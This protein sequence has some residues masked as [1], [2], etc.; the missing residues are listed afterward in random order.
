MPL[1]SG[2]NESCVDHGR[3]DAID[4]MGGRRVP[5]RA[6]I[7]PRHL[8]VVL[9]LEGYD[10]A[11]VGYVVPSLVD[12]W[13]VDPSVFTEALAVGNVGLLLKST[14]AGL[15]GDRAGRRPVLICC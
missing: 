9:F 5:D 7:S 2:S 8:V 10:I 12:V 1:P 11:A 3:Q 4:N 6:A 15:I 14:G 13:R